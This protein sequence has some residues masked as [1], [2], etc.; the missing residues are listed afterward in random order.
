MV[1]VPATEPS[2]GKRH[3][4][5]RRCSSVHDPPEPDDGITM[6]VASYTD[7]SSSVH[8]HFAGKRTPLE[9]SIEVTRRCPLECQHCYNNLD[10]GD[11]DARSREM[12]TEEHF[13]MLDELVEMGCFW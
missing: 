6:S 10:M 13:R 2:F 8:K 4:K 1:P 5:P 7:F 3:E 9:V 12:T 11:Q